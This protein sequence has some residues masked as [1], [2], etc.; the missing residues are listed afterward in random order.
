MKSHTLWL[1]AL[2]LLVAACTVK[3]GES[4]M[5]H[6][7]HDDALTLEAYRQL[8]HIAAKT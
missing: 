2:P 3:V 8:L 6:P 1:C 4:A 7:D 5:M